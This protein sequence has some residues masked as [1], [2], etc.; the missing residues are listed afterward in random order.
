[1]DPYP[2]LSAYEFPWAYWSLSISIFLKR[3]TLSPSHSYLCW[4]PSL[5]NI[6]FSFK[7]KLNKNFSPL[8]S[9]LMFLGVH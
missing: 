2:I 1:M 8:K 6:H 4:K 5:R 7:P 9:S 3:Y